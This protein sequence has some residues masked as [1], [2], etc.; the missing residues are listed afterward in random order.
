MEKKM[1]YRVDNGD[2]PVIASLSECM[3]IIKSESES[4]NEAKTAEDNP[5][6]TIDLVWLTDEEFEN[7]PDAY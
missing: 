6:W 7:L 4:Y 3:E 1:Y 2:T 5:E